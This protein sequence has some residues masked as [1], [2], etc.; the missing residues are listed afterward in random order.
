MCPKCL[1]IALPIFMDN[2]QNES[3]K[4]GMHSLALTA[5]SFAANP[6]IPKASASAVSQLNSLDIKSTTLH[7]DAAQP[8]ALNGYRKQ[9][10]TP[11]ALNQS[12]QNPSTMSFKRSNSFSSS[13]LPLVSSPQFKPTS[14]ILNHGSSLLIAVRPDCYKS[15]IPNCGVRMSGREVQYILTTGVAAVGVG[16]C[17]GTA[18]WM[19]PVAATTVAGATGLLAEML[20]DAVG[21]GNCVYIDTT[22][23]KFHRV[24]SC[25]SGRLIRQAW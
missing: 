9:G 19:C 23:E 10:N 15:P 12:F 11:P 20:R 3:C 17:I 13:A 2:F 1:S 22:F 6:I 21:R 4:T 8:K 24:I 18:G 25:N 16:V 5:S 7:I 14:T